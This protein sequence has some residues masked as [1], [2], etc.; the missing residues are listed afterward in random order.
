MQPSIEW[1]IEGI[2]LRDSSTNRFMQVILLRHC[3]FQYQCKRF[4]FG[5]VHF[6]TNASN[7]SSALISEG[8]IGRFL[9][10]NE[11][12]CANLS[13]FSSAMNDLNVIVSNSDVKWAN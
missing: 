10:K 13:V 9:I 11:L 8:Q 4:L 7:S 3:A 1:K 6:S 2:T 5:I 12:V